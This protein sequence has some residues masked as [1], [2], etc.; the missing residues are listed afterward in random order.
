M[1]GLT[2]LDS[3]CGL[4]TAMLSP[5]NGR[6]FRGERRQGITETLLFTPEDVVV[7]VQVKHCRHEVLGAGVL[8]QAAHQIPNGGVKLFG[9]DD[10]GVENQAT[11]RLAN[12]I[13]LVRGHTNQHFEIDAATHAAALSQ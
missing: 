6:G 1:E 7:V 13:G 4:C 3:A 12:R 5:M 10:R 9:V 2:G 11:D 8:I